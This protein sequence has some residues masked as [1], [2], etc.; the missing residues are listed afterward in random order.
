MEPLINKN[1]Q[2]NGFIFFIS[3]LYYRSS[4]KY[5]NR[6]FRYCLL[7]SGHILGS[8]EASCYLHEKDYE[9]VYD[10]N[11]KALNELFNFVDEKE[12]FQASVVV[13]T[14]SSNKVEKTVSLNLP[15]VDGTYYFEENE[16][17]KK[18]MMIHYV[19]KIKK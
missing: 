10:F 11:K 18:L 16:L 6:A 8:L 4:W 15:K 9:I 13:G 3:S 1:Y 2:I 19:L 12:F 17:I 14:N 7:D 5:K